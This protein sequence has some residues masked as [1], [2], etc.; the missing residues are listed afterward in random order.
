[1]C[2]AV[3]AAMAARGRGLLIDAREN[4]AAFMR[5]DSV[6]GLEHETPGVNAFVF[7]VDAFPPGVAAELL[8]ALATG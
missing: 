5:L 2:A 1:M 4:T 3:S 8:L 7:G 6:P